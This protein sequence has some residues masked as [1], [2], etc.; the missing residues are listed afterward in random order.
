VAR[1][2]CKADRAWYSSS[3]DEV[4]KVAFNL[5]HHIATEL[6][7]WIE[8]GQQEAVDLEVWVQPIT[9]QADCCHQ[10][11]EPLQRVVLALNRDE[12]GV[13]HSEGAD[14]YQAERGRGI[15]KHNFRLAGLPQACGQLSLATLVA[16]SK[17]NVNAC[18]IG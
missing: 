5:A 7:A 12:H 3:V 10:L 1:R 17:L 11:G 8:H 2:L 9:D 16:R 14:C 13:S 6:R 4:A 15:H 18:Q